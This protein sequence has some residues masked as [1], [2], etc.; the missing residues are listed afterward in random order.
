MKDKFDEVAEQLGIKRNSAIL[1]YCPGALLE[2]VEKNDELGLA[3]NLLTEIIRRTHPEIV[4]DLMAGLQK[5]D[6]PLSS[7][8][9]IAQSALATPH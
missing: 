4:D 8:S 3:L 9:D 7:A 2:Q 5:V 1:S 6:G